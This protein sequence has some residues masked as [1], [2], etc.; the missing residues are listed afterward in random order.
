MSALLEEINLF[1]IHL[2]VV[3]ESL[4]LNFIRAYVSITVLFLLSN[5]LSKSDQ[6]PLKAGKLKPCFV[7]SFSL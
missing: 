1:H 2:Q 6:P 4:D 5:V 3:F 7:Y